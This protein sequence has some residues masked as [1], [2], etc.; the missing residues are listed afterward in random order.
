MF[1]LGNNFDAATTCDSWVE[2]MAN[3][4]RKIPHLKLAGVLNVAIE[5][6][7]NKPLIGS[8]KGN[9]PRQHLR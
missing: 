6:S 2:S 4:P 5:M 7:H 8:D 1:L 9:P 3:A